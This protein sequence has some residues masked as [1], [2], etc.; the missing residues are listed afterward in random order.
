MRLPPNTRRHGWA[1]VGL[2][3]ALAVHVADEAMT[4]FLS[5]YNPTVEQIRAAYPALPL[6]TFTFDGWL[7]GLILG[8]LI[9]LSLSPLVFFGSRGM[10]VFSYVF[11]SLM[12][13]NGLGHLAISLVWGRPMPGVYSSPPLVA[14]A[15]FLLVATHRTASTL[16]DPDLD[17]G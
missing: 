1:W 13:L 10:R 2:C 9:L 16:S 15:L 6:P 8:I 11:G 5:V 14:A 12:L 4:D 7:S 17:P 3:L